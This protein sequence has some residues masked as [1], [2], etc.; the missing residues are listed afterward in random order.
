MKLKS[1]RRILGIRPFGDR[2]VASVGQ[3]IIF[4]SAVPVLLINIIP[5]LVLDRVGDVV[6]LVIL[7]GL[8]RDHFCD[9]NT[10]RIKRDAFG[11]FGTVIE[12]IADRDHGENNQ[13]RDLYHVNG[14]V[15]T[16]GG[17][18]AA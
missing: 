15:Y 3:S 6:A 7:G 13:R 4:V 18:D 9:R 11:T 5:V 17:I 1:I 8:C 10:V 2:L 16:G 14:K 12:S